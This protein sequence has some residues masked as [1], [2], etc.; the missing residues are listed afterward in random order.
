MICCLLPRTTR[1]LKE[2]L[3][4]RVAVMSEHFVLVSL[5]LLEVKIVAKFFSLQLIFSTLLSFE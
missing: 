3:N 5:E 4:V 2:S 1:R